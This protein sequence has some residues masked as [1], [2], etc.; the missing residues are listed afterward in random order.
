MG[1]GRAARTL[2]IGHFP[3]EGDGMSWARVSTHWQGHRSMARVQSQTWWQCSGGCISGSDQGWKPPLRA[4]P[5]AGTGPGRSLPTHCWGFSLQ[6]G[7]RAARSKEALPCPEPLP[8]ASPPQGLGVCSAPS[9]RCWTT[10]PPEVS[11]NLSYAVILLCTV[12]CQPWKMIVIPVFQWALQFLC[13]MHIH[14]EKG[15][16]QGEEAEKFKKTPSLLTNKRVLEKNN[17]LKG[18][19]CSVTLR[20]FRNISLTYLTMFLQRR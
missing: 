7:G 5:S 20:Y 11:S 3:G 6:P 19:I 14:S 18:N 12:R 17:I 9:H 4:A 16:E 10:W 2:G 15:K 1:A 13:M 8:Q